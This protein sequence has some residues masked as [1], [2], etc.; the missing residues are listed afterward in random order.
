MFTKVRDFQKIA[1]EDVILAHRLL[2]YSIP[3]DAY[4]LETD[5]FYEL[6]G[7]VPG[8]SAEHSTEQNKDI[9][10]VKARVRYPSADESK[11]TPEDRSLLLKVWMKLRDAAYVIARS[12]GK[13]EKKYRNLEAPRESACSA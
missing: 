2:K 4:V 9:G 5:P 12:L 8:Q 3:S 10:S 1:D 7:G 13:P 6:A 11:V